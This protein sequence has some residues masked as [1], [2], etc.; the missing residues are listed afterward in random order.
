MSPRARAYG[1]TR[2]LVRLAPRPPVQPPKAPVPPAHAVRWRLRD[3]AWWVFKEFRISLDETTVSRELKKLGFRKLSARRSTTPG[4]RRLQR[5][6][7]TL[8]ATLEV[9]KADFPAGTAID[10][11]W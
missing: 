1:L 3:L 2:L 6:S 4:M 10:L 8:P 5:I 9:I 7:K 11:G